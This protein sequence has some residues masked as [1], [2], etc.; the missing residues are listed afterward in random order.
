MT[1]YEKG[2]PI[3]VVFDKP[4]KMPDILG[5]Y[6]SRLGLKQFRSAETEKF[7]HVTFFFNDYREE[8]FDG[9]DRSI[10]PSPRDV[11]TYDQKPEMSAL[12][13]CDGVVERI[14]SGNYDMIVVNFANGDM[15]GHTG[16]L[17]AAIRAVETVDACVGR[18]VEATLAKGG[19]LV[20]TAD[21][22]NCEQLIDPA[23]GGPHTAH[24]TYDVDLIVVDE[25][26]AGGALNGNGR[27][28]DIAPTMLALMGLDRPEA[29]T[30]RSLI[31][32]GA[33]AD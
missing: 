4:P 19:A 21:H 15:V 22:G 5:D 23:T 17:P 27:L 20:V 13:V 26:L 24:T 25:H 6:V 16:S 31:P 1:G 14:E 9:E 10:I 30:G 3:R 7:P 28:A 29:M 18:I 11:T 2:L 12:E 32:D 33:L 8:P